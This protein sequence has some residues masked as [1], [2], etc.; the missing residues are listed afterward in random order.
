MNKF[1]IGY[2][3]VKPGQDYASLFQAIKSVG[4]TWWH[5][6]DST[7]IVITN[8]TATQVR[9]YLTPHMDVNEELLVI[10]CGL[11]AAW[12]GFN[13]ECSNWLAANL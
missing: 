10:S 7:W 8:R 3:P 1:V 13:E 4:S 12:R 11:P 6:L 5:C 9:D 2:D